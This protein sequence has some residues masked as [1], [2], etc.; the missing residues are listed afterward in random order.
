MDNSKLNIKEFL[1]KDEQKDLLRFLMAGSV[2]DGKSPIGRYSLTAKNYTK[3]NLMP[4]NVTVREWVMRGAY[5]LCP[6]P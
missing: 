4:S 5:R 3:T 2:D 1:D 6:T